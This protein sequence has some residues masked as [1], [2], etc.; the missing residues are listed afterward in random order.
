MENISKTNK[1]NHLVVNA[2]ETFTK[3]K[4]KILNPMT[5]K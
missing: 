3:F 1:V 5:M 2:R 4:N